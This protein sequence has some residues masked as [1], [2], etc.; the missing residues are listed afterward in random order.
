MLIAYYSLYAAPINKGNSEAS[1]AELF[2]SAKI[3]KIFDICK[4]LL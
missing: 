4:F 3:Q 1:V 2:A